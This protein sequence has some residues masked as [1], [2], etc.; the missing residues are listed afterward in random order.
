M[1]GDGINDASALVQADVGIAMGGGSDVVIEIAAI[2][3]MRYSL[4]GVADAFVI[5]RVTLYNMK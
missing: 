5:F 2:I 1:V 3:L 4:M